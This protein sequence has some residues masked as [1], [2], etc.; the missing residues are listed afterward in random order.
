MR[1]RDHML[2]SPRTPAAPPVEADHRAGAPPALEPGP[3]EP[4]ALPP[5]PSKKDV[6][7]QRS[8][9]ARW[10]WLAVLIS[11]VGAVSYFLWRHYAGPKTT[12][13]AGGR[14]GTGPPPIPV[15]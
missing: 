2:D 1:T 4:L 5:A 3:P 12:V 14:T 7:R 13:T 9:L 10:I 6:R 8:S 15:V 11:A